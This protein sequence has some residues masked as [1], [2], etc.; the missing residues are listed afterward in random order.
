MLLCDIFNVMINGDSISGRFW[1]PLAI[2]LLMTVA[3]DTVGN[4][5]LYLIKQTVRSSPFN[6]SCLFRHWSSL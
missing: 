5:S 4:R 2:F 3:H 6:F 1:A